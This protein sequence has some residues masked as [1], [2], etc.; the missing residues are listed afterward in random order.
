[1]SVMPST[2]HQ[3]FVQ[4]YTADADALVLNVTRYIS[5]GLRNGESAIVIATRAHTE[6]FRRALE[7]ACDVRSAEADR[8][9][10]F[11]DAEETMARFITDGSPD[12]A[13]FE[14]TIGAA[15]AQL[16]PGSGVRAYGE[17]VGVLWEAGQYSAAIVLED[18]WNRLL[19]S[20]QLPLFCAYPIDVFDREF[21]MCGVEALLCDHSHVISSGAPDIL[22]ASVSRAIDERL[23]SG[24]GE[25]CGLTAE[26]RNESW[27]TLP[28]AEAAILWLRTNA[29]EHADSILSRARQYYHAARA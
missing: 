25:G 11:F 10:L 23:G 26:N 17:M 8:R 13:R 18:Y 24:A 15:I 29:P 21:Q 12:W 1:M 22:H 28:P 6:L 7:P 5:E 19:Q 20:K 9:L 27:A 3:H 16:A 2:P 14:A 4:F